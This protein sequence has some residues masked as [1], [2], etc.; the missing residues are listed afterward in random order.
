MLKLGLHK[1][2]YSL[3]QGSNFNL[4]PKPPAYGTIPGLLYF[5]KYGLQ[6]VRYNSGLQSNLTYKA[7]IVTAAVNYRS[8]AEMASLG[9]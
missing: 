6:V 8:A 2:F 9:I 5:A 1:I 7:C 4:V 3:R